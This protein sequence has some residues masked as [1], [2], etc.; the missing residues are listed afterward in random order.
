MSVRI[1]HHFVIYL[2]NFFDMIFLIDLR[3]DSI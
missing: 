2:N 1:S 3:L